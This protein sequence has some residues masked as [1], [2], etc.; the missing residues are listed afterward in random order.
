MEQFSIHSATYTDADYPPLT[1][2]RRIGVHDEDES[3]KASVL[4]WVLG[5]VRFWIIVGCAVLA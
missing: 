5:C 1:A 2:A 3:E 4:P